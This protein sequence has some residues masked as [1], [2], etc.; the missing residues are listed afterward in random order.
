MHLSSATESLLGYK[1]VAA[2][3]VGAIVQSESQGGMG[4]QPEEGLAGEHGYR[5]T[6]CHGAVCF[7]GY[8]VG[9]KSVSPAAAFATEIRF[10]WEQME[11][12]DVEG[13]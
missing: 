5:P 11:F 12:L 3:C 6:T 9:K 8:K 2:P 7:I 4:R 13:S 1:V 10:D